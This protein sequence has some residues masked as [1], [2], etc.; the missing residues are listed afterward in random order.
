M[1]FITADQFRAD[2]LAC[3]GHP[4]IET[5]NLDQLAA[6]GAR[7]QHAYTAVP[8]CMPSRAA[9]LTGM[10]QWNHGRLM[11]G[12][13]DYLEFPATLPGEM[14]K[15]GYHTGV[16][17]HMGQRPVRA[18]YGFSQ[19][20]YTDDYSGWLEKQTGGALGYY[21]HGMTPNSWV[22]R[23][24]NVPEHLHIT[25]WTT[26]QAIN[27][28]EKRDPTKP[29]FLW[30]SYIRPHAP[31]DPPSD[32]FHMYLDRPDIPEPAVG[33]WASAF[34]RRINDVDAPRTRLRAE[35][36]RRARAGYFGSITFVDHQIG[37]LRMAF[38]RMQRKSFDNTLFIFTSDHGEM[39]GDHHH[40]RKAYAYESSA[41][42]PFIVRWPNTW[43][44]QCGQV[45]TE[46]I[47]LRDVMPTILDAA[48]CAIP[49]SVDGASVFPLL[50]DEKSDWREFIQG[51]FTSCYT[52]ETGMQYVTDGLEKY[53]WFHHTGDEQFF[54][55][56]NDPDECHDL[57]QNPEV[58]D[59]ID[60]WRERLATINERRG[61]PRGKDGKLVP[62][63][64]RDALKRSPN[65]DRW[66]EAGDKALSR[67]Q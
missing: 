38:R 53:I 13:A 18:L 21:D 32:Y 57:S 14:T 7:F 28:I 63:I 2:C 55:L 26:S 56:R 54:D 30:L 60:L 11:S 46:P 48:E 5:P 6:E 36:I 40:W 61:D 39:L 37:R 44:I 9:I 22:A 10:D 25:H 34:D 45:R 59:R 20:T 16:I 4:V 23:P 12:G 24:S 43:N 50:K 35:E 33:D 49:D 27:F 62:Q 58:A 1:I 64:D 17:G 19:G 3:E 47:E 51:E 65:Y 8:T 42:I 66:K 67:V 31:F 29:F 15:A 52:R 41:R